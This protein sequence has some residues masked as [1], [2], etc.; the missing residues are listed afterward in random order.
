LLLQK[1][2]DEILNGSR[3]IALTHK[4]ANTHTQMDITENNPCPRYA[5]VARMVNL[6]S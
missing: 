6:L 4:Q 5:I 2:H 3:A 1:F